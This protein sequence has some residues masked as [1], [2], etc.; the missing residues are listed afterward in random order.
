MSARWQRRSAVAALLWG[1]SHVALADGV[2]IGGDLNIT[3]GN[4]TY[5]IPQGSSPTGN[6]NA[7]ADPLCVLDA[8]LT[9]VDPY[10]HSAMTS[11]T[12]TG[13]NGAVSISAPPCNARG[14]PRVRSRLLGTHVVGCKP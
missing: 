3:I 12:T 13:I 1:I 14:N 2:T 10:G 5:C 6:P 9:Y 11:S 8:S 4:F 7:S